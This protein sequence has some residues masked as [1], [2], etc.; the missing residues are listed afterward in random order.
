M[1][2]PAQETEQRQRRDRLNPA[3]LARRIQSIQDRLTGI[4]RDTT[5]T[6]QAAT[7]RPLPDTDRGVR[8]RRAS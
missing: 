3:D 8:L 7:E 2:S 1:P 4:A 6:L 5:L